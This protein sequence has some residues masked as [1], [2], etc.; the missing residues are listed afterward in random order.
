MS[1]LGL[2]LAQ[3][4][5]AQRIKEWPVIDEDKYD[6]FRMTFV[7]GKAYTRLGN[8]WKTC[9]PFAQACLEVVGPGVH[10][11]GEVVAGNWNR[12]STLLKREKDIDT[13]AIR[14]EVTCYVFDAYDE[15]V[16]RKKTPY[17]E[18]RKAVLRIVKELQGV[19]SG[20]M[21]VPAKRRVAFNMKELDAHLFDAIARGLE[22][23]MV[24]LP[25]EPY[26][27]RPAPKNK[28]SYAWMKRKPF[29]NVTM[30][31]TGSEC[32]RGLCPTCS[33]KKSTGKKEGCKTCGGAGEVEKPNLL[34]AFFC[35][36]KDGKEVKVGGGFTLEQ[37]R[38]FWS[39]RKK[40]V[41][42]K[43]GVKIQDEKANDIV[44]RF[45]VFAQSDST[46][47]AFLDKVAALIKAKG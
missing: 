4:F 39:V 42:L 19:G 43:I 36:D 47:Q 6:G 16:V 23:I 13:E 18:R 41:G 5:E 20:H 7:D 11:D 27:Y 17:K 24:K 15:K 2:M 22:G 8:V 9:E 28:R 46:T 38:L 34:G 35:K 26:V 3:V 10:V 37:R 21:F 29:K 1:F 40:L 25:D 32:A 33:L 45:P 44:A 12:T 31:I 30:T 14:K